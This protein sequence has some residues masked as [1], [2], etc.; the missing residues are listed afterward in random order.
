MTDAPTQPIEAEIVGGNLSL[1]ACVVGTPYAGK[2]SGR[3]L[4][5]EDVD[6]RPYRIDRMMVQIEQAGGLDDVRAIILGDFTNCDD[7][8]STCIKP[9]GPRENPRTLLDNIDQRERI[10]LR[11]VFTLDEALLEIFGTIGAR[12]KIPIATGLPVGHGPNFNPL[13]LGAQYRLTPDGKLS[14][15][16]WDWI[17]CD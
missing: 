5:L 14:L 1:W 3:I 17:G 15:V 16:K 8:S 11:K 10:P 2:A 13:P 4:F 12:L 7:E 9:L 6:E